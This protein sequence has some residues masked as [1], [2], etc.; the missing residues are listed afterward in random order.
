MVSLRK[1]AECLGF[2]GSFSVVRN[3]LGYSTQ[4]SG[5]DISL[6]RQ[7][8]LLQNRYINLNI[9]R[10][11]T[12]NFS[13]ADNEEIDSAIQTT[14]NIYAAVNLGVGRI[15]RYSLT[16]ADAT[17]RDVIADDAEAA[18]LTNEWTV[19]NRS[20][21]VFFVLNGWPSTPGLT[22]VGYSAVNG[23]CDKR[24]GGSMTGTVVSIR[25]TTTG[26]TG[27]LLAHELAHYLG[28]DHVCS[29]TADP[30]ATDPC[31]T[32]T[33]KT[34]HQSSLMFPC[35]STTAVDIS[36]AEFLNMNDHC[37]VNGGCAG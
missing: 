29:L 35:V 10:V 24:A 3:F 21:D 15:N 28:L 23:P 25:G 19:A 8:K 1:M 7:I 34:I 12:D 30:S 9:I 14:R 37:F 32:G 17:G 2:S 26:E 31:L 16:V 22:T 4:F 18:T 11:G 13:A 36:N 27:Q 6:I 33:C 20:L 5:R